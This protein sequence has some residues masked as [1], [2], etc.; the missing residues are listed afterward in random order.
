MSKDKNFN[1]SRFCKGSLIALLAAVVISA[2]AM[3]G[4]GGDKKSDSADAD[5]ATETQVVTDVVNGVYVDSNGNAITDASGN[6]I[7]VST[8]PAEEGGKTS[9]ADSDKKTSGSADSKQSSKSTDT[10][11]SSSGGSQSSKSS[12]TKQSSSGTAQSSQSGKSS[13]SRTKTPSGAKESNT[14]QSTK[15]DTSAKNLT[16]GDKTYNVGDKVVCTYF[17]DV[18][19]SMLNFQGRVN[20]DSS[21]L[22][23]TNA[24]LVEPANGGAIVNKSIDGKII[25]NGSDISGYDFTDPGYEFL[26]VEY[27]V[28]K[29]GTTNPG[30]TFEVITDLNDKSYANANGV[31]SGGAKISTVYS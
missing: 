27:E 29:T 3:A 31:L 19:V 10:K 16:I 15:A 12:G 25:F 13:G 2:G 26:V 7:P 30:I 1:K 21:M 17:L 20:Y 23:V 24:Y 18:P 28:L 22:K 9:K 6:P 14:K 4:C 8:A 11:Q 5:T